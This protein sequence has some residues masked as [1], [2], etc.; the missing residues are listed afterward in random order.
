MFEKLKT[1]RD[2]VNVKTH[3]ASMETKEEFAE[4]EE[5]WDL[6]KLKVSDIADDSKTHQKNLSQ[7]PRLLLKS[8]KIPIIVLLNVYL[9]NRSCLEF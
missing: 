6:L 5:K 4:A 8:L 9:S 3:L 7:N 2:E 1:E